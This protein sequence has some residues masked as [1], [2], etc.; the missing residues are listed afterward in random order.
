MMKK[1]NRIGISG[2]GVTAVIIVVGAVVVCFWA[3]HQRDIYKNQ[4]EVR[5]RDFQAEVQSEKLKISEDLEEKYR[6]DRISYEVM[7]RQMASQRNS[8]HNAAAQNK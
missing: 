2:L 5:N 3:F 6:A 1:L 8:M 4:L 7:A